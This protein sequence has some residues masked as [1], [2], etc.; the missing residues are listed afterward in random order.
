MNSPRRS[1]DADKSP[2]LRHR[3]HRALIV[4]R[5]KPDLDAAE[6]WLTDPDAAYRKLI[7]VRLIKFQKILEVGV[8]LADLGWNQ[9][10]Q[11]SFFVQLLEND[12]ELERHPDIGTL[13][14]P[15]PDDL[16]TAENWWV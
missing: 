8:P 5:L 14:M 3:T 2:G 7:D 6:L 12:V 13:N 10:E 9:R 16:F 15:V 4:P 1:A 11:A